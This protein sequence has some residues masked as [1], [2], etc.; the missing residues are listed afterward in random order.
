[1]TKTIVLGQNE[2]K[3]NKNKPIGIES[4]L[5]CDLEFECSVHTVADYEY[6]TLICK[7]YGTVHEHEDLILLHNTENPSD[8]SDNTLLCSG[9]WN[10]GVVQAGVI[11]L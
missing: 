7:N 2:K 3:D 1:M 10:D 9:R 4:Y 11:Q 6:A 5:N 8:D